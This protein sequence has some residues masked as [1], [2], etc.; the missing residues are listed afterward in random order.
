MD[1]GKGRRGEGGGREG[2]KGVV[3]KGGRKKE[4]RMR[5]TRED[6]L[7]N[8]ILHTDI[9][10]ELKTSS[11]HINHTRYMRYLRKGKG[12]GR[13]GED[14]GEEEGEEEGEGRREEGRRGGRGGGRGGGWGGGGGGGG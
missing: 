13:G 8:T 1:E 14:E 7:A 4:E 5:E 12:R 9:H 3:E 11:S 6:S 2:K 10:I